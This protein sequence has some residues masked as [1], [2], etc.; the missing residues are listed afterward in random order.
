MD[1]AINKKHYVLKEE[2]VNSAGV[3]ET[4]KINLMIDETNRTY[5]FTPGDHQSEFV[6]KSRS[7][8]KDVGPKWAAIGKLIYS[9]VSFANSDLGI[10]L[11]NN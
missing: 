4:V 7:L 9:A 10:T 1:I 2:F 8:A 11:E 6:F 3:T 5:E